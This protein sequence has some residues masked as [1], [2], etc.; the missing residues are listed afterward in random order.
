MENTKKMLKTAGF[1]AAA[2]FLAK[3]CGLIRDMLIAAFFGTGIEADAYMTATRLPTTLFDIVIGGVIS[4]A[5]IPVFNSVLEKEKREEALKFANRFIGMVLLISGLIAVFG[6]VFSDYLITFMAPDF[7]KEAHDLS[8][9]LSSI[10][11]PMIIFT[12]LAFSFVG[13]L[14]S[15]GEYNIPAVMSLV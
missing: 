12:G 11:F 1:M 6:I 3:V 13:I 4:A 14:Q 10:M 2:T 7:S 9:Q 15:F 8:R 5:F